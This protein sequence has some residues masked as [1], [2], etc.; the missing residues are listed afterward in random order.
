M[1]DSE[2]NVDELD[3]RII[4]MYALSSSDELEISIVDINEDIFTC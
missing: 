4:N 2:T 1:M 3:L